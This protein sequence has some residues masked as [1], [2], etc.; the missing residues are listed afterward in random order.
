VSRAALLA[1]LLV[2]SAASA[3]A[4]D[5]VCAPKEL[6]SASPSTRQSC[7]ALEETKK[8]RSD[9]ERF[10]READDG[11]PPACAPELV[12]K[13]GA[14]LRKTC[15]QARKAVDEEKETAPLAGGKKDPA[16][17]AHQLGMRGGRRYRTTR[18]CRFDPHLAGCKEWLERFEEPVSEDAAI[19]ARDA[20]VLAKAHSGG[21]SVAAF[22]DDSFG[23]LDNDSSPEG[24]EDWQAHASS[25]WPVL[26]CGG[27]ELLAL[28]T[29]SSPGQFRA[30]DVDF[31][32]VTHGVVMLLEKATQSA[33]LLPFHPEDGAFD[34][35]KFSLTMKGK[36]LLAL[37]S[38]ESASR[39]TLRCGPGPEARVNLR[40]LYAIQRRLALKAG[41]LTLGGR[42]WL[43]SH[44]LA[45]QYFWDPAILRRGA[46]WQSAA[47]LG[48]KDIQPQEV[49][50]GGD[51]DRVVGVI[52]GG[53]YYKIERKKK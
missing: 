38:A 3:G 14:G 13:G 9:L 35:D 6:K 51:D 52:K 19:E 47:P 41:K 31:Q 48:V 32:P 39:L 7:A 28:L 34:R 30:R 25:G 8:L 29:W 53:R 21:M 46:R 20:A 10:E 45:R 22:G 18:R 2:F 5:D 17:L 37:T 43:A 33:A 40:E 27:F 12:A 42:D 50:T 16:A 26:R 49:S 15:A 44:D 23:A 24:R 1:L 4:A 36:P 11:M